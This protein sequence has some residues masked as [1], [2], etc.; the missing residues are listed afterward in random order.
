MG[1][2]HMRRKREYQRMKDLTLGVLLVLL[3]H[4]LALEITNFKMCFKIALIMAIS[5]NSL[6]NLIIFSWTSWI[7]LFLEWIALLVQAFQHPHSLGN[8]NIL[9]AIGRLNIKIKTKC[10]KK[11]LKAKRKNI[12]FLTS[13][14]KTITLR[15]YDLD[16]YI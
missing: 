9:K 10:L 16:N 1:I 2:I 11:V 3:P 12:I 4:Y 14:K 8:L 15:T 5:K 6:R 13:M 7:I